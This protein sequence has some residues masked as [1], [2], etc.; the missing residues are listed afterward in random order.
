MILTWGLSRWENKKLR[1]ALQVENLEAQCN[2][3]SWNNLISCASMKYNNK[4]K[5]IEISETFQVW[6][7][8][9]D[10]LTRWIFTRIRKA[11]YPESVETLFCCTCQQT[12][13]TGS[14]NVTFMTEEGTEKKRKDISTV[15]DSKQ[16]KANVILI[17]V[18]RD[19]IHSLEIQT[20][21][22]LES[23]CILEL[24]HH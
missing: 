23:N 8:G 14:K 6:L 3:S 15:L 16:T 18:T 9:F 21:C 4:I 2:F 20:N 10:A 12:W 22:N 24:L 19:S 11:V 5:V 13:R 7:K 1:V 17:I